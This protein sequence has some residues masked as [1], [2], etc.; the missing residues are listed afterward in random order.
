[1][2]TA[3][4]GNLE[5]I[6]VKDV[7]PH[8]AYDLTPWLARNIGQLGEALN[9]GLEAVRQEAPVGAFSLDILARDKSDGEAVVIEN[10]V[11]WTDLSHLGQTLTYAGGYDARTLIWVAPHFCEEHRVALEWLNHWTPDEIRVF[12]I[13]V[14]T[15]KRNESEANLEFVPV[16]FPKIWPRSGESKIRPVKLQSVRRP[17]FFQ[18]LINDLR[19]KG[20]QSDDYAPSPLVHHHAF[21]SGVS[22]ITYNV[23][24]ETDGNAWV[25]IP[26]WPEANKLV[27][28]KLLEERDGIASELQ[29]GV[30]TSI[31]W[32][33]PYGSLG[34]YRKATLYDSEEELEEIRQWMSHYLLKF[35]KVFN[36]RMEKIIAELETD[37]E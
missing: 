5:N 24:F 22:D 29:I 14:H 27:L 20:L 3:E 21:A 7:W 17:R 6:P 2:E 33:T 36:P 37:D 1:M 25:Y 34:V 16:V 18:A 28:G 31:D 10:Q 12:G 15:A 30:N 32:K 35:K 19:K 8:E 23:I 9:M 26:G 4:D 11:E 13:E